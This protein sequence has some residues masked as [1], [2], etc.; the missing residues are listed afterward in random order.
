MQK[1]SGFTRTRIAPT[2]SGYLHL[3]NVYSFS[4][5]AAL[6]RETGARILLRIDDLDQARVR[7]EYVEDIFDTLEF[8]E[9]PW[10]EGPRTYAEYVDRYSQVYRMPL[11][12]EALQ[13]L[14]QQGHVFACECSRSV[15]S[16]NSSTA[17]YGG[18]CRNKGL[19]LD[20]PACS[21]RIDTLGTDLP[22]SMQDF[23]VRRRD[24]APAYQLASVVDDVHDGV[25]LIV[26]GEDLWE[27]T[28]G[29]I[30]L[31]KLLGYD[32]FVSAAFHHH[33]LL[34]DWEGKKL[35][36][37][38]GATSIQ[39]LRKNGRTREQIYQLAGQLAGVQQPI[40]SWQQLG[41]SMLSYVTKN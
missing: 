39:Y 19:S 37:S 31:A 1:K 9:L 33:S 10:D 15:L 2:P 11:Y 7:R 6:A 24:G 4:I 25:D 5:T 34:T 38:S 29:Q 14:R 18:T 26:R 20:A 12:A 17:G 8:L 13:Q 21:W 32:S 40:S 16:A 3:G 35:A 41:A 28:Q 30:H 23:V 22:P 27:S 36:K